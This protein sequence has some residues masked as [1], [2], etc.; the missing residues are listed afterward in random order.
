MSRV[1]KLP[2]PIPSGVTVR[3]DGQNVEIEGPRGRAQHVVPPPIAVAESD[4]ALSVSRQT[5]DRRTRALHGLTRTLLANM[6]TGLSSGFTQTLEIIGVG[7]RA[8]VKDQAIL[9]NIGYSHPIMYQLPPGVQ[10]KIDRQTIITLEAND[11]QLL[12]EVSAQIRALRPPEPY[13]GKGIQYRGERIRRKAG[14]A[15]AATTR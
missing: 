6:I 4:G 14:K 13:K 5:D 8:E 11:R 10:A 15:A 1:G 12:G 3:Q 2:I 9:L 7:Y